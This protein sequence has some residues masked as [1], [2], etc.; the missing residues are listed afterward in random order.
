[1]TESFLEKVTIDFPWLLK[2]KEVEDLLKYLN[3]ELQYTIQY[4]L[5]ERKHVS[6]GVRSKTQ[7]SIDGTVRDLRF[8]RTTFNC[9]SESSFISEFNDP[10][11]SDDVDDS[12][13]ITHYHLSFSGL[14]FQA[15]DIIV[16][17]TLNG[18]TYTRKNQEAFDLI[19]AMKE[20]TELFFIQ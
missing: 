10:S 7:T 9:V 14:R 20:K 4:M 3:R 16:S 5:T 19:A 1:M 6:R 18:Y 17:K 2:P 11:F 15:R 12:S 13:F 8:N